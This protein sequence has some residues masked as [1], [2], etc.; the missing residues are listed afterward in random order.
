L[1][2]PA[3]V[4]ICAKFDDD[5]MENARRAWQI[6]KSDKEASSDVAV[7]EFK[8]ATNWVSTGLS[9]ENKPAAAVG[10]NEIPL[11]CVTGGNVDSP[12]RRRHVF[13][14]GKLLTRRRKTET[15]AHW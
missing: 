14:H 12:R 10:A 7:E 11:D 8:G 6:A 2:A 9:F 13:G 5:V 15:L 4:L 1:K 3:L